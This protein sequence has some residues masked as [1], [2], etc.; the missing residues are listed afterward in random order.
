MGTV[1]SLATGL[2]FSGTLA[3]CFLAIV[4]SA[5]TSHVIVLHSGAVGAG[6]TV[7][8]DDTLGMARKVPKHALFLSPVETV[9]RAD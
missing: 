3:M 5:L 8:T 9:I 1:R 4:N 7:Y 2:G 6:S